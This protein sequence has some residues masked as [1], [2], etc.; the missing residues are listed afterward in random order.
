MRASELP[1]RII[2]ESPF[3]QR[4]LVSY[5]IAACA[6][7]TGRWLLVRPVTSPNF[8]SIVRGFF[9]VSELENMT[10]YITRDECE[11]LRA[12]CLSDNPARDFDKLYR[13]K[14]FIVEGDEEDESDYLHARERFEK[15]RTDILAVLKPSSSLTSIDWTWPKGRRNG[16]IEPALDAALREFE[17]ETGVSTEDMTIV[18]REPISE[19]YRS[20][21]GRVY[22]TQ[23][24]VGLLPTEV[25]P[26][27]VHT[28]GEIAER[29]WFSPD[30][31]R[32]L[33]EPNERG[34]PL[35]HSSRVSHFDRF[36]DALEFYM[37]CSGQAWPGVQTESDAS[38]RDSQNGD[39]DRGES[40]TEIS[41]TEISEEVDDV[42]IG[43]EK[44]DKAT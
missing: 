33:F 36:V 30:E 43:S 14:F 7:D 21:N 27:P 37:S 19:F 25:E 10:Q 15:C 41:E 42:E 4:H 26:P 1:C 44:I 5:G 35:S 8:S 16:S 9:R 6:A 13:R 24:W 12:C 39:S 29:R 32:A 34:T 28:V 20:N 31:V 22:E 18:T 38:K 40:E 3:T 2:V 17:E 11:E 23:C